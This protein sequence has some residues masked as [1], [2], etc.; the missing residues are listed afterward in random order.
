MCTPLA[1][2]LTGWG[3]SEY[4]QN[5]RR[6]QEPRSNVTN[7]YYNQ[8]SHNDQKKD[9]LKAGAINIPTSQTGSSTNKAY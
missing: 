5:Q 1:G 2:G 4:N 8:D 3:I 9:S 6:Q 7:N